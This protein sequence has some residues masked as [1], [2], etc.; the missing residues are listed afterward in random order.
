MLKLKY[1]VGLGGLLMLFS[2]T[3]SAAASC[4]GRFINPITDVCWSCLFPIS[5]GNVAVAGK[6][7]DPPNPSLPVCLC[8]VGGSPRVGITL[9][10]WEPARLADVTQSPYCFVNMGGLQLNFGSTRQRGTVGI[11]DRPT[12]MY[13]VHWYVYPL[14][15]WLNLLIDFICVETDTFDIAYITELDPL[16]NNDE[17]SFILSPEVA[18]FANIVAQAACAAD[19]VAA[20]TKLSLDNLFWCAGC[21]GSIYPLTGNVPFD[22]GHIESSL[23]LVQRMTYKLHRE[24][25]LWGTA[26]NKNSNQLCA[27]YWQP[28]MRASTYRAQMTY[29]VRSDGYAF[30]HSSVLWGSGKEFPVKGEHFGFLVWRKRNC[31]AF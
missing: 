16:W 19:C 11:E 3:T 30:G 25:L 17:L 29:P 2:Q 9:G 23:L 26:T 8:Q 31:C 14:L 22:N 21:Q 18:L 28:V 4:Q 5:I 1:Y 6:R 10:F 20:N 15:Y 7:P 24:G 13:H 12:R 27:P